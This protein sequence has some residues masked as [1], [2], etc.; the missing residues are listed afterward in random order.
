MQGIYQI[1]NKVNNKCYIGSSTN[2]EKRIKQHKQLLNSNEHHS[3]KFQIDWNIYDHKSFIYK[4]LEAIENL[5]QLPS[6]ESYYIKQYDSINNGYNIS[7]VNQKEPIIPDNE[8]FN[9]LLKD[10]L[11]Y[12]NTFKNIIIKLPYLDGTK[13]LKRKIN[14]L[15]ILPIYH[16]ILEYYWFEKNKDKI[17]LDTLK[18]SIYIESY[19]FNSKVYFKLSYTKIENRWRESIIFS[20]HNVLTLSKNKN[21]NIE[22]SIIKCLENTKYRVDY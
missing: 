14:L 8:K 1:I 3:Y 19:S 4:T 10:Y 5:E 12:R 2:I 16:Y 9:K 22:K 15:K 17:I 13:Q 7:I 20:V 6:K 18:P 11:I 21:I